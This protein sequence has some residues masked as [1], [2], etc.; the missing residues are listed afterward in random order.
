MWYPRYYHYL[1]GIERSRRSKSQAWQMRHRDATHPLIMRY[2]R[3]LLTRT[4]HIY[5]RMYARVQSLV[6]KGTVAT[7]P[8]V[9]IRA[10]FFSPESSRSSLSVAASRRRNDRTW[11]MRRGDIREDYEGAIN[12]SLNMTAE[13]QS[14]AAAGTRYFVVVLLSIQNSNNY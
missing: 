10:R 4:Q 3:E 5:A 8:K 14:A 11:P 6:S 13:R 2:A 12:P 9:T 1:Q 7:A